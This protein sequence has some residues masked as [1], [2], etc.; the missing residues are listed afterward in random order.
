MEKEI[1]GSIEWRFSSVLPRVPGRFTCAHRV[2]GAWSLGQVKAPTA[3]HRS[4][5]WT[6]IR[7]LQDT[8]NGVFKPTEWRSEIA[9]GLLSC[10]I[11]A[12]L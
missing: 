5:G 10:H 6:S 1:V 9:V 3:C 2:P 11:N 4:D 8:S 12:W 7:H